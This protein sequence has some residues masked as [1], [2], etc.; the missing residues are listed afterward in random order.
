MAASKSSA[1]QIGI[2]GGSLKATPVSL[3]PLAVQQEIV[4]RVTDLFALVDQVEARYAQAKTHVD[5]LTQSILAKAFRGELVPQDPADEPAKALLARIVA[6]HGKGTPT[7]M[8][9]RQKAK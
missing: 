6:K 3:P 9:Q 7:R 5:R 4:R 8:A 2:S 1:G